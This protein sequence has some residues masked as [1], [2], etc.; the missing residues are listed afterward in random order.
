M[1]NEKNNDL[2][3]RVKL[4]EIEEAKREKKEYEDKSWGLIF[5][6]AMFVLLIPFSIIKIE[7]QYTKIFLVGISVFFVLLG[8]YCF[9]KYY[10]KYKRACQKLKKL[11]RE[12]Y[13]LKKGL[14]E[15]KD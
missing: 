6:T 13:L 9:S 11:E 4:L 1:L 8:I 5:P 10:P 7:E 3:L 14:K 2:E 15:E 12:L